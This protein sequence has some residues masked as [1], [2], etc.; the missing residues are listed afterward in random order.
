MPKRRQ[1]FKI[2]LI[3][4]GAGALS[5]GLTLPLFSL[6]IWF[7]QLPVTLNDT[8]ALLAF[9]FGC[10]IAGI[11]AGRLRRQGGFISGV[12]SALLLLFLLAAVTLAMGNLT[13][14][15]FL[16]RLTAAVICGAVGG[17]I[18]VNRR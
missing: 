9:S 12:K 7:L 3:S 15:F 5:G 13:G 1:D 17:V 2:H 6:L 18:G 16:G 11:T 4:A 10:L 8:F 14:E